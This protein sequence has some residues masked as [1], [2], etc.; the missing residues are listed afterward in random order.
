MFGG[1]YSILLN[2]AEGAGKFKRADKQRFYAIARGSAMECAAL[3][4]LFH[5]LKIVSEPVHVETKHLL[6][7]IVAMLTALCLMN[8]HS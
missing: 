1:A 6:T 5:L 8:D 4:D 7:R 2:I 3:V